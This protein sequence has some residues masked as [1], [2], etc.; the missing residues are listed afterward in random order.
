LEL[1]G[2]VGADG[3]LEGEIGRL[4]MK[5]ETRA[6]GGASRARIELDVLGVGA[7]YDASPEVV[8]DETSVGHA[9]AGDAEER[10][11]RGLLDATRWKVH[12]GLVR[13]RPP[14]VPAAPLVLVTRAPPEV[15]PVPVTL[16]LPV[17]PVLLALPTVVA[18]SAPPV[19]PVVTVD[20][21]EPA[22]VPVDVPREFPP[23]PK[24]AWWFVAALAPARGGERGGGK[25][26]EDDGA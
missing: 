14:V 18:L 5:L 20:V 16:A 12:R 6:A 2:N 9:V 4:D 25:C 7:D 19:P 3:D 23:L 21:P 10:S 15:P 26:G 1:H 13:R 8:A 11:D 17:P 22:D 24:G